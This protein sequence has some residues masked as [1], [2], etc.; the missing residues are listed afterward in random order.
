M[1]DFWHIVFTFLGYGHDISNSEKSNGLYLRPS[2]SSQDPAVVIKFEFCAHFARLLRKLDH[3]LLWT[4]SMIIGCY[5]YSAVSAQS[6]ENFN[7]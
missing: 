4:L 5:T 6:K 7:E 2:K 3:V 1:N